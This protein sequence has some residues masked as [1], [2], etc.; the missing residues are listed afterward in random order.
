MTLADMIADSSHRLDA[1]IPYISEDGP[2]ADITEVLTDTMHI[3]NCPSDIARHR[4]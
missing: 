2:E 1:T 4:C 3:C